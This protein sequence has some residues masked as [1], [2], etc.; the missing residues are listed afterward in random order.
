MGRHGGIIPWDNDIDVA[1][2]P[3]HWNKLYKF[4]KKFI[5][6]GLR[7]NRN[8]SGNGNQHCHFGSIDVF[9]VEWTSASSPNFYK[10]VLGAWIHKEEWAN[11][12]KQI[13]GGQYIYAPV[14]CSRLLTARYGKHYYDTA[15]LSDCWHNR[16]LNVKNFNLCAEDRRYKRNNYINNFHD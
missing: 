14:D 10:G 3:H 7:Y 9:K 13:F 5:N 12:K 11:L 8:G 1:V 16:H 6:H 15:N 2:S 4:K